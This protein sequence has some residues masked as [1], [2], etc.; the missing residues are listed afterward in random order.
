MKNLNAFFLTFALINCGQ[1]AKAENLTFSAEGAE[2]AA[3]K[4][5]FLEGG[6]VRIDFVPYAGSGFCRRG[7]LLFDVKKAVAIPQEKMEWLYARSDSS[8]CGAI[9]DGDFVEFTGSD[10]L[11]VDSVDQFVE[12]VTRI[13]KKD[14]LDRRFRVVDP[15]NFAR[16]VHGSNWEIRRLY[17]GMEL[18]ENSD[19]EEDQGDFE[20]IMTATIKEKL[21]GCR[22]DNIHFIGKVDERKK[23]ITIVIMSQI[24]LAL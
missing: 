12:G 15:K 18:G 21:A 14:S 2:I 7:V 10:G 3:G 4:Y 6:Q 8:D 22:F 16:C 5:E 1:L 11:D 19:L 20:L 13:A 17:R 23:K 9:A 24:S